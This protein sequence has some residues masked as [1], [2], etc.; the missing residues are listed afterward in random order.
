MPSLVAAATVGTS[1]GAT[2]AG[3]S[4]AGVVGAAA[5][6]PSEGA[7][8]GDSPAEAGELVF[9][10]HA[11]ASMTAHSKAKHHGLKH[12]INTSNKND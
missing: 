12:D 8:E 4:V 1:D 11:G 6:E 7:A 3:A 2:S 5:A 9:L 10:A